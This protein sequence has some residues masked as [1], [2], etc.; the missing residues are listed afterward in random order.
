MPLDRPGEW[1]RYHHLL[2]EMLLAELDRLEP[3]LIPVL[4]R[5]AASWCLRVGLPEEALEYSIA[6]GDVDIVVDLVGGLGMQAY[7]QGRV[8]TVRR[9]C[10]WLE[11]RGEIAGHP[12]LAVT[13]GVLSALT[14]RPAD[15]ERW[16]EVAGH[17]ECGEAS[18]PEDPAAGG[19]A[20]LLRA[21]LCRD[22]VE[23][24]LADADEAA[25]RLAA[26]GVPEPAAVLLQGVARVLSG[27]VDGGDASL[28]DAASAAEASGAPD[29][30]AVALCERSLLATGRHEW[31]QAHAFVRRARAVLRKPGMAES[32]A[33]PLVA[34]GL[35]ASA[36]GRPVP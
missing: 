20:A 26:E 7:R 23:Q 18:G 6:I 24:M 19:W 29:V 35:L 3:G 2:R 15:A 28:E 31:S 16:A 10:G 27:D 34:G 21:L 22:G 5:R 8:T 17:R 4:R 12:M 11:D 1:Y 30:V 13:A 32:Y 36:G 9:W 25:R 33:I 14:G